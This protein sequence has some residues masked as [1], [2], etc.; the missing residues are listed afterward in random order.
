[1]K[2]VGRRIEFAYCRSRMPVLQL[3]ACGWN[4]NV[5]NMSGRYAC[6]INILEQQSGRDRIDSIRWMAASISGIAEAMKH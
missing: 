6:L 5:I 1:M 4:G 2:I 3:V